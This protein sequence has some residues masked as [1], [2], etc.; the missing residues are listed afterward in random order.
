MKPSHVFLAGLGMAMA[1]S[2]PAEFEDINGNGELDPFENMELPLEERISDI[3]SRLTVEQKANLVI[4]QGFSM[5]PAE[6]TEERV[7]GAAG[8]SYAIPEL[9]IPSIVLAD[10]PAGVRIQP[11]REGDSATY[12]CTAF[13]IETALASSWNVDLVQQVGEALGYEAKEYGVDVWLAP[14]MNLHRNP[15]TGRNFE[16]Y[17]ED[18]LV[19]G[20]MAAAATRGVQEAGV[21]ATL[22]HF[23]A[24]NQETNRGTVN[25]K[26]SERTLRELYLRS[27]EVALSESRPWTI[28]SSY[29]RLNGTYTSQDRELLTDIL[30]GE[31][32]FEGLVMTDWFGGDNAVEQ[33]QAGND[34]LMPGTPNQLEE[35]MAAV[36]EGRLDEAVLDTNVRR[37]LRVVLQSQAAKGYAYTN[38]PD[39][40]GNAKVARQAAAEGIVL[41]KNEDVLPLAG[42][43]TVAAFGNTSYRFISGGTGSGDVN[44]A[45]TVS[46]VQGLKEAGYVVT[47]D[48]QKTYEDYLTNMEASMPE[49]ESWWMP[50]ELPAEMPLEAGAVAAQ[51]S[52]ADVALITLGRTSGEFADRELEGDFYLT[53]GE[54]AMIRQVSQAFR[55]Q[56]KPVIM[57][58]NVG[59]VIEVDTW[60]PAVDGLLVAWQGGQEAGN[61][62][63]DVLTGK[64]NPSGKLATTFPIRYEDHP[65][66]ENFP[67]IELSDEM[68]L[69]PMNFPKGKPSE[70]TYEE[71]LYVGYRYFNTW[72]LEVAYPFGFGL[73]YT[74]FKYSDL[75]VVQGADKTTVSISVTN[76]GEVAG[77][78]VVQLYLAA[79]QGG[80]DKPSAELK[81]FAKTKELAPGAS[82]EITLTLTDKALASYDP[83]RH[84]WVAAAGEYTI[85]VGAS[86]RD[87]RQSGTISLADEKLVEQ[88]SA[89]V[90]PE[91]EIDEL[92]PD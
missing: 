27:F 41:L 66:A 22:K 50:D 57:V 14:A 47:P 80:L 53:E 37:I 74:T 54:L 90:L 24:N 92:K 6:A 20:M 72:D 35:I 62:V 71:G 88:C 25:T 11:T 18:P 3:L 10:G 46:L 91:A 28:M 8:N 75:Q 42:G 63:A 73:S 44:E 31:W 15:R 84:A 51:A 45:Y 79:P 34:L 61:A 48:L 39:L 55:A 69:G 13:P 76:T 38:Q 9:G 65:S 29:N 59:N 87:I 33:M 58:L 82:Q 77:K 89:L 52:E 32:G 86:S 12:Y 5:D 1:C 17:S 81:G 40:E 49:K 56:G 7:P 78:A 60:E 19:S 2:S 23:V 16:Y 64:V 67:G 85:S 30:R 83:Q 21:C 4:G 43:A 70:V 36:E 26:V 68:I